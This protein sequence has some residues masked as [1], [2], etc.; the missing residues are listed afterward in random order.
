M[1]KKL[2]SFNEYSKTNIVEDNNNENY[3]DE[4]PDGA[5]WTGIYSNF[6]RQ[7]KKGVDYTPTAYEYDQ[8]LRNNYNSPESKLL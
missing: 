5:I 6:L 2:H 4:I 7:L 8:W 3:F 1:K